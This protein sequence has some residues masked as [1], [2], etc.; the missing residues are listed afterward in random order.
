MG[1]WNGPPMVLKVERARTISG[2]KDG[3]VACFTVDTGVEI[4]RTSMPICALQL[5]FLTK[6]TLRILDMF[7]MMIQVMDQAAGRAS[8]H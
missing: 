3:H 5:F 7:I 2:D 6:K 1:H 4:Y 8:L